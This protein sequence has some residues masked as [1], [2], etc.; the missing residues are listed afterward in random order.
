MNV[1][2]A[3]RGTRVDCDEHCAVVTRITFTVSRV[4]YAYVD[5]QEHMRRRRATLYHNARNLVRNMLR[6]GSFFMFLGALS[7]PFW[8]SSGPCLV[9]TMIIFVAS[10]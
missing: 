5:E 10:A 8:P 1:A 7:G 2:I 4:S 3:T 9:R 6:R